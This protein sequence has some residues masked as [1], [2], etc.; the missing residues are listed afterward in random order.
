MHLDKC[1]VMTQHYTTHPNTIGKSCDGFASH[2]LRDDFGSRI[3]HNTRLLHC[4]H[5]WLQSLHDSQRSLLCFNP[6]LVCN[7]L[8]LLCINF[9]LIEFSILP[10]PAITFVTGRRFRRVRSRWC[11]SGSL[12][13]RRHAKRCK[14]FWCDESLYSG[15]VP[16]IKIRHAQC[17]LWIQ[18]CH[19]FQRLGTLNVKDCIDAI[20]LGK[21]NRCANLCPINKQAVEV[22]TRT[23]IQW[24]VFWMV[25]AP[26]L[27][28]SSWT[29]SR[30]IQTYETN[31]Q[32][33]KCRSTPWCVRWQL[34]QKEVRVLEP[35]WL[36]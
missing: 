29:S 3:L 16:W 32:S 34:P 9:K 8:L 14:K 2:D 12:F 1:H 35:K 18:A 28:R 11:R 7:L 36:R 26:K 25:Y 27:Q 4:L 31:L 10:I 24:S 6:G 21:L 23:H 15:Y 19:V 22:K 5:D 17:V 33:R 30:Q 20:L 13:W